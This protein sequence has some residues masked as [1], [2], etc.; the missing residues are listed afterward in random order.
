VTP[1]QPL[2]I[3]PGPFADL[4]QIHTPVST[5]RPLLRPVAPPLFWGVILAPPSA[6]R[7]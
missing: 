3:S 6:H 1:A 4:L 5:E 7:A 2:R